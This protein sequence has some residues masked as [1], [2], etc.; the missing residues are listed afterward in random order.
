MWGR[1]VMKSSLVSATSLAALLAF[2]ITPASAAV[3]F[4]IAPD[5]LSFGAALVNCGAFVGCVPD[6]NSVVATD[7]GGGAVTVTFGSPAD[8]Q[9]TGSGSA[10]LNS[11]SSG[12]KDSAAQA[13]TFSP[14]ITTSGSISTV[15]TVSFN[16][17]VTTT[18]NTLT[19]TG[20]AVAPIASVAN[21]SSG[22]VLVGQTKSASVLVTNT[23]NGNLSGEGTISNLQGSLG[24]ISGAGV[25][26]G[27]FSGSG[28][29]L[30]TGATAGLL[31]SGTKSF[32][33]SFA[34]TQRGAA[35]ATVTASFSNGSTNG[36]NTSNT[37]TVTLVGTGVAPVA[38][39]SVSNNG[40]GGK[41]AGAHGSTPSSGQL[42]YVL[43]NSA[44][45]SA[46]ATITVNNTGNGN[47]AGVDN[48]TTFL[49]NLHGSQGTAGSSVFSGTG[50]SVNLTDSG[51][52]SFTYNF[53]P[54]TSGATS[55]TVVT[56]F[57]NSSGS[58]GLLAT[59]TV[60]TTLSGTGVAPVASVSGGNAGYTLV[61]GPSKAVNVTVTNSGNGNLSGAGTISNLNG[62][63]SGPVPGSPVWAGPSGS[64]VVALGDT[65][66]ANFSYTFAPT[67]VGTATSVVTG[68]FSNGTNA[69]NASGSLNATVT[70]TG[71]API[72]SVTSTNAGYA[73]ANGSTA[74]ATVTV[75]NIGNG[76][77]SGAGTV[78]NLNTSSISVTGSSLF[79]GSGN[80]TSLSLKDSSSTVLNYVFTPTARGAASTSVTV[81]FSNG[82]SAGT[83]LSQS[84]AST[85]NGTGVG[86][87]Y[88]ST[89]GSVNTPTP[90]SGKI[91]GFTT[92]SFGTVALTSKS[93]MNMVLS[94]QSF[95]PNGG[96]L[97]LTNLTLISE[98]LTGDIT[99]FAVGPTLI[100]SVLQG[101]NDSKNTVTVP[102]SF[103]ANTTG[104]WDA[105]LVFGTDENAP[106]GASG[107]LF[108]YHL[109]ASAGAGV[110]EPASLAMLG[111][112]LAGLGLIR[113]RRNR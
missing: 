30:T 52:T 39:T 106:Y 3:V 49:S 5:P 20:T 16:N 90:N 70:G 51:S 100:G 40:I 35:S 76:N 84:V 7:S 103:T 55:A 93:T 92:V 89:I 48:G 44:A 24:S 69:Q 82:N 104:S 28:G 13:Y 21:G 18:N 60:T 8:T 54:T 87:I 80:P 113:R 110:P 98:T 67:A 64:S 112:G 14:T 10:A 25:G 108:Y 75:N 11:T 79:T 17:G 37:Q 22:F 43:V 74:G 85:I 56:T 83:N 96:N 71:V 72:N 107:D 66:S 47:L 15:A 97:S 61:A 62:S 95:D 50:G 32:S 46:S 68:T 34:P 23:G 41:D 78:S 101:Q 29:A 53:V 109:T 42:G 12:H 9:F 73:R 4:S 2:E 77:L 36:R 91:S 45:N 6:T 94:N 27:L 86:P 88:Q 33:Y 81:N 105:W 26:A 99:D 31:D 38:S 111:A 63:V 102:I 1:Y 57:T 65:S 19:L 58:Q 59:S